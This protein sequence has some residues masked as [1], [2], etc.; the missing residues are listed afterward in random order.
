MKTARNPLVPVLALAAMLG[1]LAVQAATFNVTS[2]ADSGPGSLRQ[3]I[4]DANASAGADVIAFAATGTI[5]LA[6]GELSIADDLTVQGPGAGR[7]A[8]DGNGSS[9][10]LAIS[11][12][13]TDV[14]I[15]GLTIRNGAVTGANG[16][17]IYVAAGNTL[18]LV[19][20][21]VSGNRTSGNGGGIAAAGALT[22]SGTTVSG[23]AAGP[24]GGGIAGNVVVLTNSTIS[25][26]TAATR[27]GGVVFNTA[28]TLTNVTVSGN[29]AGAGGGLHALGAATL[30]NTIVANSTGGDCSISGGS[31]SADHSLVEDGSCGVSAGSSGN[32]TGDPALGPLADN[33]CVTPGAGGCVNTQALLAG[34]PAIDAGSQSV[35]AS[36]PVNGVDQRGFLRASPCDMGAYEFGAGA[37]SVPAAAIPALSDWGLLLTSM[38]LTL[39]AF[40]A[41]R[42]RRA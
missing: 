30:S 39:G 18:A 33:G 26:N 22:L 14:T 27:G 35:C 36:A 38:A 16:G 29:T 11:G 10:V 2:L 41:M 24:F 1:A 5:V 17:G 28:A 19:D 4:V 31:L 6:G 9:R 34:S 25:G 37:A 40:V 32:L 42:R 7:L 13:G 8:I 21:T 23:N 12:T 3:A 20:S 15:S